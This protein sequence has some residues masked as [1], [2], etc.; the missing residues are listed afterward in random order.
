MQGS[1]C[2]QWRGKPTIR[3][4]RSEICCTNRPAAD[5]V[6]VCCGFANDS[7]RKNTKSPSNGDAME[8]TCYGLGRHSERLC[9]MA[10]N[11]GAFP[12]ASADLFLVYVGME[13]DLIFNRGVELPGFASY[14]LLES[15]GGQE[16]LR[17]YLTDMVTLAKDTGTGVI[18]ES[19]TWVAN[20]DRAAALGYTPKALKELNQRAIALMQDV[21]TANSHM[22]TIISANLGPR[23]DAYK[24]S[25]QMTAEESERYHSEQISF[26]AETDVDVISGYTIAYPAEAVGIVRA[27]QRFELRVVIAFTVE[28]N[29]RLPTGIS[30]EDAI[31]QV[32]AATD[33]YPAYFMINCAHPEHFNSVLEDAP[34]M[35][36]IRGI[37][38]NASRCSHAELD[39]AEELD[40]G[41]PTE[42]G[43]QL[44][45]IR[46]RFP[47]IQALGGCCG[48]DM[49]HMA[50]IAKA[51]RAT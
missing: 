35:Q 11:Q 13:T 8:N 31:S 50:Q 41:N 3:S 48:T 29:G 30:L 28:T 34:W 32:D 18:L 47:H 7:F 39:E 6:V 25:E 51:A 10:I 12:A 4:K 14:P 44:A 23:D 40:D 43:T 9:A 19:P 45:E 2:C 46:R 26:L 20:R 5:E 24:P 17:G 36:R 37:V 22:P 15:A 42:L 38:A 27:A 16:F 33:G 49:R 21:R 1:E